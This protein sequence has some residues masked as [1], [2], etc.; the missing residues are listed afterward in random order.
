MVFCPRTF[1]MCV[2]NK[3]N[4]FISFFGEKILTKKT[5]KVFEKLQALKRTSH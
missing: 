5:L 3:F 1:C 4:K 2:A